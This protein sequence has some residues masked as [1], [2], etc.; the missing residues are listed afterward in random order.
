[1]DIGIIGGGFYGVAV[2]MLAE[3]SGHSTTIYDAH[4]EDAASPCAMGVV[5]PDWFDSEGTNIPE[6]FDEEDCDWAL[7]WLMKK[8]DLDYVDEHYSTMY[9]TENKLR[10]ESKVM[11]DPHEFL[12]KVDRVDGTATKIG[13]VD[14]KWGIEFSDR[15]P[16]FHDAVVVAAGVHTDEILEASGFPPVGVKPL[17]GRARI[18]DPED[19]KSF[20]APHEYYYQAYSHCFIR[21]WRGNYRIG[22]SVEGREP[23]DERLEELTDAARDIVGDFDVIDQ[24]EGHRP[25]VKGDNGNQFTVEYLASGAI[26]ATGGHRI[27]WMTSPLAAKWVLDLL[28]NPNEGESSHM[29]TPL[30][31]VDSD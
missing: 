23:S 12:Q 20:D 3:E 2:S 8:G 10:P 31:S 15:D 1:M 7:E 16:V 30:G 25:V 18:I 27:G 6:R 11:G 9:G 14:G 19:E 24:F 29:H 28:E 13:E 5:D 22:D 4:S 26:A 17:V 21:P